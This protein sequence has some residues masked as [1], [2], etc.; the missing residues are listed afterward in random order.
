MDSD[1]KDHIQKWHSKKELFKNLD[2]LKNNIISLM[3][4]LNK[5]NKEKELWFGKK[6]AFSKSIKRK[7]N[8]INRR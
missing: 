2:K 5:I 7:I 4:E 3:N 1:N 6:D 8:K